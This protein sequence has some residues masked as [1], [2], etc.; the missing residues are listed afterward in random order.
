M[1]VSIE[2]NDSAGGCVQDERTERRKVELPEMGFDDHGD[3]LAQRLDV[4]IAAAALEESGDAPA[5]DVV[6][7][8]RLE[9]FVEKE[10]EDE[11]EVDVVRLFECLEVGDKLGFEPL[12]FEPVEGLRIKFAR[13]IAKAGEKLLGAGGQ[14]VAEHELHGKRDV[15]HDEQMRRYETQAN[16]DGEGALIRDASPWLEYEPVRQEASNY[17]RIA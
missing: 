15:G 17:L 7:A 5:G 10:C 8:G 9:E 13:Q 12:G 1:C 2:L 6:G 3:F 11:R 4:A 14:H 16:V